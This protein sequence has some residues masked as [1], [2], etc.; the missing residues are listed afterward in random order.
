MN[1]R[2]DTNAS[3]YRAGMHGQMSVCH[4]L[5]NLFNLDSPEKKTGSSREMDQIL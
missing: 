5:V 4:T 2:Q 3:A 1:P